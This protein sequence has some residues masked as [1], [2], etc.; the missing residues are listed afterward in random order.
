MALQDIS[1]LSVLRQAIVAVPA[2]KWAL[3]VG[4]VLATVALVYTFN[5]N[6]RAAFI[7]LLL[8]FIF[9]GILV[10]FARASALRSGATYW[11]AMVFTW[12]VLIMFMATSASLFTSMFF[13]K[14][15]DLQSWLTGTQA[16]A[17]A[18]TVAVVPRPE[19]P[20]IPNADSG[21]V[22]G[23]SSPNT[24][25]D[26]LLKSYQQKYPDFTITMTPLAEQHKTDYN[27]FKQDF[28]RYGC[29]FSTSAK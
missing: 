13:S 3:G 29:A 8:M 23:G 14:P 5:L 9:M 15:L 25:C 4:G 2:V 27:P 22:G 24:F 28:Y 20:D 11:P 16:N 21:W 7:G 6:P 1:P 19:P 17:T 26:P 12:F 18:A 10:I